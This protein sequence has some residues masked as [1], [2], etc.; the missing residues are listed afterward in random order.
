MKLTRRWLFASLSMLLML[1]ACSKNDE[2]PP[3]P[4]P[5]PVAA[6]EFTVLATSDLRDVQPLEDM[7]LK[8]TGVKLKFRF[9]GTME[10]TEAVLT[11]EAKSAAAW[12]A[13][14]KYLLASPQGQQRVKLQEKIMLSPIAVGVSES[15]ARRYGW[16]KPDL[17]LTWKDIAQ[18]AKTGKLRY[19]LSN[20][21]TSNQGF[22]ALMGVVAA[23]G[24]KAEALSA[25]DV[26]RGAIADFL[27][28][29]K[30]PGDNST[31]LSEQFILQQGTRAN[32]FINYESW[33]LS[34]NASGKLREKLRLIYPF[35]GVSTADYPLMLLDEARRHG[36]RISDQNI[37]EIWHLDLELN[38]QGLAY[39]V[40]AQE[41]A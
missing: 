21:A 35:E 7:A 34:L 36:V 5:A 20:P 31:Y 40:E 26:D 39:W 41:A 19:A 2:P 3:P 23:S 29:Y 13:N 4:P 28:G 27:K 22:M 14:A 1:M 17:K 9:G 8:A 18:A 30:I 10:S 25:D 16:D 33:L 15:D 6:A 24:G 38:A 37:L 12:F 11:G 32:A